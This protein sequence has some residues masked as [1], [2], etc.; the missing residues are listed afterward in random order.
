M[1]ILAPGEEVVHQLRDTL[2]W[3]EKETV[4]KME[5]GGVPGTTPIQQW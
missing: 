1:G 3:Q 4:N 5:G 2:D